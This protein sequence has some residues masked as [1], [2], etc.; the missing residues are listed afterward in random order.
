MRLKFVTFLLWLQDRIQA[1][2]DRIEDLLDRYDRCCYPGC[3]E[4]A[5]NW[6]ITGGHRHCYNH[7][8]NFYRDENMCEA[9]Y[10]QMTPEEIAGARAEAEAWEK[11]NFEEPFLP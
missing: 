3:E 6:C 4:C 9:C 11:E 8:S 10:E 1:L 5:D 7:E 2:S